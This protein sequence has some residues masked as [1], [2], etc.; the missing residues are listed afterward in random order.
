MN[1]ND[2]AAN[3]EISGETNANEELPHGGK[4]MSLMDHLD[5]LRAVI[6]RS[7]LIVI[8][9]FIAAMVFSTQIIDFLKIP[10]INALPEGSTLHFTGPLD[11]FMATIQVS[12]LS[13]LIL[14]CPF[15]LYQFW[16]FLEPGLYPRE[17]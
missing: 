2:K 8:G 13:S 12:F 11:P 1:L 3:A 17:R 7:A 5:E 6:V 10:L 9:L 14:G 15:W 4:V 16:K